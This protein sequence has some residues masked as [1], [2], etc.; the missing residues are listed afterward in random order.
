MRQLLQIPLIF[1]QNAT[2]VTKYDDLIT[3]CIGTDF[4]KSS[5]FYNDLMS[6]ISELIFKWFWGLLMVQLLYPLKFKNLEFTT[7][8]AF[9]EVNFGK[10]SDIIKSKS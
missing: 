4:C 2:G 3:K 6:F 7:I 9:K 5:R 1:L 10:Y 8:C